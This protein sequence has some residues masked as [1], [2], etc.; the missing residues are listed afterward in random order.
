MSDL[1]A[2]WQSASREQRVDVVR[3]LKK[4]GLTG[5]QIAERLNL[6]PSTVSTY[7]SDP[8]LAKQRTRRRGYA[9]RCI[10]CGSATSGDRPGNPLARCPRCAHVMQLK[11][12]R[13]T[14]IEVLLRVAREEG[15]RPTAADFVSRPSARSLPALGTIQKR[16]GSFNTAL[17]AAGFGRPG[18]GDRL[19][20]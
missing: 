9:G 12:T 11:W 13:A 2:K 14:I 16:F 6:A 7:V 4:K 20:K 19:P 5:Q 8:E 18:P 15:R 10:D 3:E 17:E 1:R